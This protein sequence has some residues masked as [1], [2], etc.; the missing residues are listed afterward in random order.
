MNISMNIYL[1]K[2]YFC[3]QTVGLVFFGEVLFFFSIE[4]E[5]DDFTTNTD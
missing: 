2:F 1:L 5:L 4:A 3:L